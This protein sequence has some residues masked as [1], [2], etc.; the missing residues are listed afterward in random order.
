MSLFKTSAKNSP[1]AERDSIC[2]ALANVKVFFFVNNH[3]PKGFS[4]VLQFLNTYFSTL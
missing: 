1:H 4:F 2:Q 3:K